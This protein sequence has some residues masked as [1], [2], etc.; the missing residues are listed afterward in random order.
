[1]RT[2]FRAIYND[3]IVSLWLTLCLFRIHPIA[4]AH[5]RGSEATGQSS[6]LVLLE[7]PQRKPSDL[8]Y[9]A[10]TVSAESQGAMSPLLAVFKSICVNARFMSV[11]L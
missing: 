11:L 2:P 4:E 6:G 3:R 5:L 1:M 8:K 7:F 10:A 9:L